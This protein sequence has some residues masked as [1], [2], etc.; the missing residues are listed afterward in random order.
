MFAPIGWANSTTPGSATTSVG[1]V[2]QIEN[3]SNDGTG[4]LEIGFLAES[5]WC[6]RENFTTSDPS[7]VIWVCNTTGVYNM[8]F[9]QNLTLTN[10][11]TRPPDGVLSWSLFYMDSDLSGTGPFAGPLDISPNLVLSG[12][13]KPSYV[14]TVSSTLEPNVPLMTFTTPVGFL[15]STIIPTGIWIFNQWANTTDLSGDNSIY[16][17][18]Y[19]VDADGLSNPITV[20]D[21]SAYA[22]TLADGPPALASNALT[23]PGFFLANLTRRVQIRIFGNFGAAGPT[24][25]SLYYQGTT[26]STLQTTLPQANPTAVNDTV[27]LRMTITSATTEFNQVLETSIPVA[28]NAGETLVYSASAGGMVNVDAGS[29]VVCTVASKDEHVA[30][31]SGYAFLPSPE[32]TLQ[33][34]LVAQGAY[35]NV[36]VVAP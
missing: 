5:S 7:G 24:D 29:Q 32:S 3:F 19:T 26:V 11:P 30:I 28:I 8:K 15:A 12:L 2:T 31:T 14:T 21:G 6:D 16:Y 27:N 1:S 35:G 10:A 9:S 23:V 25:I 17:N 13:G 18:V 20:F 34:N 36:G 33:W 4:V 22:T